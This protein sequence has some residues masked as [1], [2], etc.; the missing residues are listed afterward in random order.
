MH[1]ALV[2][3]V[4]TWF[5]T[6]ADLETKPYGFVA[7]DLEHPL[8]HDTNLAWLDSA[9]EGGI[10][11]V[12]DDL[13]EA[14]RGTEVRDRSLW[15]ADA[16]LAF[17]NQDALVALHFQP[18]AELVMAKVGLPS[19][20][21]NP[22]LVV[23]E[24]GRGASEEDFHR[25]QAAIH[26]ESGFSPEVSHQ[27]YEVERSRGAALNERAF[28]GYLHEEAAGT[29]SLLPRGRFGLIGSVATL[30]SFRMRGIGRTMIFD[31]CSRTIGAHCEYVL[32]TTDL[33]DSPQAMYKSLGFVPV[34]ELRG[35]LRKSM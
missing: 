1:R 35:F 11:S 18:R 15:F 19:C 3:M 6:G 33:F 8:L 21:V 22:D 23:E 9:P 29:Y 28:V 31:A 10:G 16:D 30:P 13:D 12:L 32:L 4:R 27:V 5:Q 17:A 14:F 20:I 7:R 26:K 25:V 24:V 2:D 34:G